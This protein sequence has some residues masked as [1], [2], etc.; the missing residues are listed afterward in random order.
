VLRW[1]ARRV[2]R[3]QEGLPRAWQVR[4]I[5]LVGRPFT[6]DRGEMTHS[7]KL[8]RRSIAE[9]FAP[10]LEAASAP[11]PRGVAVVPRDGERSD[12]I[13][14]GGLVAALWGRPR[15]DDGGFA[16]AA[17]L[18]T[19]RLPEPISAVLE[20]AGQTLDQCR[21][22]GVLYSP[23]SS[24]GAPPAA[25]LCDAPPRPEG[26][27]TSVAEAALGEAGLW[28]IAV[29]AAHGGCGGSVLDLVRSVTRIAGQVPT[30]AGMLAVHSSIGAVSAL[31]AFGTPEQ[32][33]RHLPGLAVGRPLSVFAAT[34]PEVGCDLG[35]VRTT[36]T[37]RDGRTVVDGTKMFITNATHGRLV[38]LLATAEGK[39]VVALVRLPEHDTA[40]FRL[41]PYALHP[42]RHTANHALEFRG[43]QIDERDVLVSPD[44]DG[45]RIVWHGLNRGRA[46]LAAQAA[47]TLGLLARHA[48]DHALRRV[49]W[50]QPIAS[51]QLVQG[52]L[53]RIAAARMACVAL[54]TWAA[55]A[56]DSGGG[57]LEAI[58]AKVVASRAVREGAHDALGIHGG[59]AFLVGH[60]LGDSL[61]DH[62]AVGVYEGES[63]LLGL[64]LFK[65]LTRRHPLL[66]NRSSG[67]V[68]A[69]MAW[70]SW[71]VAGLVPQ[72][73]D[74]GILDRRLRGHARNARR[75]L[76]S[77]AV[78]IDGAIRRHG[79]GL[80]ER[81][82]EVGELSATV[83]EAAS[84]LAVAHHADVLGDDRSIATADVWCRMA[85]ARATGKRLTAADHAAIAALGRGVV[86]GHG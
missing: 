18:A 74:T 41:L 36:L 61:H 26:L 69:A 5:V 15:H 16:A 62:L 48:R 6:I 79:R 21:A 84:V 66:A 58:T 38:K 19:A 73:P 71:R 3:R 51:R 47:G 43:F 13:P 1:L 27:F 30:A 24:D 50:G 53:A 59:R 32:Q 86:D 63:E 20:R 25:P 22:A 44:G 8:K 70:L 23:I 40:E 80:A 56:I 7:M 2:A 85:L 52:R 12:S 72:G 10:T 28:G 11:R 82:L 35:A 76:A 34:E 78:V 4:R 81:Q 75:V 9:H 67:K 83:R 65:G 31:D 17:D 57:E 33:S 46:T 55:A 14:T 64:A 45:M 77:S 68:K 49:T 29:P 60:P 37:R 54:S 42:L 39:P